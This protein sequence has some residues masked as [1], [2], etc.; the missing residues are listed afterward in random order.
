MRDE[1]VFG[2]KP[3]FGWGDDKR[4]KNV[5]VDFQVN[6]TKK[7]D[8]ISAGSIVCGTAFLL[9]LRFKDELHFLK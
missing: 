1:S 6:V 3:H 5:F 7:D 4:Q 8:L 9:A 2:P